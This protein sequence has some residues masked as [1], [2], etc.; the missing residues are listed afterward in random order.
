[1]GR[2]KKSKKKDKE[3]SVH[4]ELKGLDLKINEFGEVIGNREIEDINKFLDKHV[5]D[6]KL[7]DRSGE[8]GEKEEG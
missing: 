3:A 5:D 6:K 1:M 4:D 8:Y 2:I 7:E